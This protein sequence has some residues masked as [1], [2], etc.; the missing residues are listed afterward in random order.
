[1]EVQW[2]PGHM[3]KT[4]RVLEEYLPLIDVV[5]DVRDA[6][7]PESSSN[8]ELVRRIGGRPHLV[9]LNKADLAEPAATEAWVRRLRADGAHAVAI[10]AQSGN[11]VKALLKLAGELAEPR[12]AREQAK[13]RRLRP[14]RLMIAGIPNVGKSSLINRLTKRGSARTGALP[15]LTRGKQWVRISESLELLDLPGVLWPKF[16]DPQVG[17]RLAMTGAISEQVYDHYDVARRLV[18]ELRSTVGDTIAARFDLA[19]LP[20]SAEETLDEIGRRRGCLRTGGAID[21]TSAADI[22]LREFR[23]GNFGR[24]TLEKAGETGGGERTIDHVSDPE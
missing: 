2:Y 23:L 4:L 14:A 20:D 8:P 9:A 1:M 3:A 6:R 17:F 19:Q 5:I 24:L 12:L 22:L 18:A 13:G 11:G 10:E 16:G 21:L 7:I 15:G